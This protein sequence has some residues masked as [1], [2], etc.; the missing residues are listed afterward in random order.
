MCHPGL[1]FFDR[2]ALCREKRLEE[3]PQVLI[4]RCK[5]ETP[6]EDAA[7]R[8]GFGT[9]FLTNMVHA[10]RAFHEGGV[11]ACFD[12][13]FSN[14][15]GRWCTLAVARRV[16]IRKFDVG[17]HARGIVVEIFV[18]ESNLFLLSGSEE[19]FC[20]GIVAFVVA[21]LASTVSLPAVLG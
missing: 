15:D 7:F 20:I 16:K 13:G 9:P 14:L 5:V 12:D 8:V 18:N 21:P 2:S 6:H 10:N 17:G 1:V 11:V 19:L 3:H 4:L